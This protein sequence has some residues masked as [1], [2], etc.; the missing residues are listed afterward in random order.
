MGSLTA[1]KPKAAP[2]RWLRRLL[3]MGALL[4]LAALFAAGCSSSREAPPT[5]TADIT[6][7][8][9]AVNAQS[10]GDVPASPPPSEP[11]AEVGS[12]AGAA[13]DTTTTSTTEAPPSEETERLQ[14]ELDRLAKVAVAWDDK[15]EIALAVITHEGV[16]A[17]VNADTRHSSASAA[18]SLW[19]AA[20]LSRLS[21]ETV[22]PLAQRALAESGN[23]AAGEIIDLIGVNVAAAASLET[24]A[25]PE[26]GASP[27]EGASPEEDAS[28]GEAAPPEAGASP[29]KGAWGV[30]AVNE[31]TEAVAELEDTRLLAWRFPIG[32]SEAAQRRAPEIGE[33]QA[34]ENYT[35]TADLA[36][37]YARL[38]QGELLDGEETMALIDW[39]KET[40]D[41]VTIDT[42]DGAMTQR[43]PSAV[44][45]EVAHKAGWLPPSCCSVRL[46][47]DAGIVPLPDGGWFSMAARSRRG[48]HYELS[49]QWVALA[50]CRVYL[51]L[52]GEEELVC[53]R[54]IDGI[55]DPEAW[56]EPTPEQPDPTTEQPASTTEQ[57]TE[58][59][60]SP[61]DP[62]QPTPEQP[63]PTQQASEEDITP[64]E[65]QT[66]P[67]HSSA[68]AAS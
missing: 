51:L 41:G 4:S 9:G 67:G 43:L 25:P 48:A 13:A 24:G 45:E 1:R 20:A 10:E 39:L 21:I 30:S 60:Q 59:P 38:W 68:D 65:E 5:S 55:P 49:L 37:F 36:R 14:A 22:Q 53:E 54:P 7:S 57:T 15:A 62:T 18:K 31:W 58:Q 27:G 66:N 40:E 44:A 6:S 42:V 35:T 33:N 64:P 61:A 50:A 23:E 8:R 47:L 26:E 34:A 32:D 3:Y 46:I 52:S 56:G 28:A 17:G 16:S 19:V 12:S 29:G 11:E 63:E 2:P